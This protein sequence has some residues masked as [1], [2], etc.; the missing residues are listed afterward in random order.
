MTPERVGQCQT[1]KEPHECVSHRHVV[2]CG[3]L[4]IRRSEF[5]QRRRT[6]TA[7]FT[8][9][10]CVQTGRGG[11]EGM[12]SESEA[13]RGGRGGNKKRRKREEG[14]EAEKR[15]E[16]EEGGSWK[17]TENPLIISNTHRFIACKQCCLWHTT[18]A[19]RAL[20]AFFFLE[21]VVRCRRIASMGSSPVRLVKVVRFV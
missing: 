17:L 2:I 11:K 18:Y 8:H 21:E 20:A 6:D 5:A 9:T 10:A 13:K 3:S 16:R 19:L 15:K 7:V 1:Q 14:M 12:E 4:N